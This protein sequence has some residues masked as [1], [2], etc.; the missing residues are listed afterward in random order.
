[1]VCMKVDPAL[2]HLVAQNV[3]AEV[4]TRSPAQGPAS[5][6]D[7]AMIEKISQKVPI[8]HSMSAECLVR[9]LALAD[10]T[11]LKGGDTVFTEGDVGDCFFILI[12]GEVL[13]EKIRAGKPV[14][15]ARLGAGDCFG[16]MAL[17]GKHL[18]TATV[19][20]K[21]DA[22]AMRFQRKSIDNHPDS[23]HV[24]YR[25]MARILAS[26]LEEAS[27]TLADLLIQT[28]PT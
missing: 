3:R 4:L 13:V 12:A 25:N 18:R 14:E 15:L 27:A 11:S 21:R 8:F 26:R 9:T 28:M 22:I 1:M 10:Y 20:C 2:S 23:A 6:L 24:I 17:V 7:P 5:R 16:E 19:R